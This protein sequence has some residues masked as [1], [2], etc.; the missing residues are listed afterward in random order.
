MNL[1]PI[2]RRSFL[3][4]S[5]T[6]AAVAATLLTTGCSFGKDEGQVKYA[7]NFDTLLVLD[8]AQADTLFAFAE[9]ILPSGNGF[10]D[11]QTA[12]VIQRADEEIFFTEKKIGADVKTMLDVMEYLPVFYGEFSRFSK[13]AKVDRLTFLESL[14]DTS[15]ETV[16]TVV[17]NCRMISYNMYYGHEST[18]Q[19]IGYDGPFSKVPQKL[20]E[21]RRY[22]A[23]MVGDK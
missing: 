12:R 19:A 11:I 1:E 13:M 17:N 22:Y 9:A 20:G 23:K 21:Q 16:R 4:L 7:T 6:T 18:W 2:S 10:P 15:N 3:R 14:S 5:G 8:K